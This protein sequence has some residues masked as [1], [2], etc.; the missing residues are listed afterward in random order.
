[1]EKAFMPSINRVSVQLTER[2]MIK[3]NDD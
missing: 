2:G 1:M 3:N